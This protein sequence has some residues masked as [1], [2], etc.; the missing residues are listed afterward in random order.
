[1]RLQDVMWSAG[2]VA[3]AS[4]LG[5]MLLMYLRQ[6]RYVFFPAK[7]VTQTPGV[8]GLRFEDIRV[9]TSDGETIH[10]WFVPAAEKAPTV[11]FCHGNGGNISHRLDVILMLHDMGWNACLFDYRGY[12]ESTGT[13]SEQ[14]TYLD[15]EAVWGHLTGERG[16]PPTQVAV[17]GESLGGAVAAWVAETK[18]PAGLVLES[19]FTTLPDMAARLYPFMPVR[20]LCRFRYPTIDRLSRI[21]CPVLI[22]HSP[23]DEM[24]PFV[25]GQRLYAAAHEPRE[26]FTMKGGHNTGRDESGRPFEQTVKA[27]L[28]RCVT[29][30]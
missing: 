28:D 5:L 29:L 16:L 1:M 14:G 6:S 12:G 10:G 27:F 24:V 26:F 19:T 25:L 21:T 18:R 4:Y 17:W 7:G 2:R 9:R 20:W 22:A 11:L 13:P 30:R 3:L 23:D 15:A 8:A